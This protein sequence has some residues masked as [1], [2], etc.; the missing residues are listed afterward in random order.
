[1]G[2]KRLEKFVDTEVGCS[3]GLCQA[4]KQGGTFTV[5]EHPRDC[6]PCTPRPVGGTD[7]HLERQQAVV[8]SRGLSVI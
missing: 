1:M 7:F 3:S 4:S 8:G 6:P 5:D 2:S